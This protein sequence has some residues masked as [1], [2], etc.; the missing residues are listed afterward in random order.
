M[1][2]PRRKKKDRR[3]KL[4]LRVRERIAEHGR[5]RVRVP[6]EIKN[7]D[8]AEA[9]DILLDALRAFPGFESRVSAGDSEIAATLE[10]AAGSA[11]EARTKALYWIKRA[12]ELSGRLSFSGRGIGRIDVE[13]V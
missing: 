10:L 6:M 3:D 2:H 4:V 8:P 13:P 11:G 9:R 12:A 1:R 5:Y 7:A